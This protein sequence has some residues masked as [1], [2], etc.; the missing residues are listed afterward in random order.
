MMMNAQDL[1]SSLP[2]PGVL[3]GP[4]DCIVAINSAADG[5]F[6]L[7]EKVMCGTP[8]WDAIAIDAPIEASFARARQQGTPLFVNDVDVGNGQRAPL[9]CAVQIAPLNGQPNHMLLMMPATEWCELSGAQMPHA[10]PVDQSQL[11]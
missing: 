1:W 6:N 11:H 7:S 5:F 3:I 10:N 2:V 4:D 8:I 9:Q